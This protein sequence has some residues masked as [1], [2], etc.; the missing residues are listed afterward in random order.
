MSERYPPRLAKRM[1]ISP[2]HLHVPAVLSGYDAKLITIRKEPI[3]IATTYR[4][5]RCGRRS[6]RSDLVG[7][8]D[9]P[10]PCQAQHNEHAAACCGRRLPQPVPTKPGH[11]AGS[12]P[13]T[14]RC[15]GT[16]ARQQPG[17]LPTRADGLEPRVLRCPS[18][19]AISTCGCPRH[20]EIRQ[21]ADRRCERG[22]AR[23]LCRC[24]SPA[25]V[26]RRST[27]VAMSGLASGTLISMMGGRPPRKSSTS[28]WT[29]VSPTPSRQRRQPPERS[30]HYVAPYAWSACF[31]GSF[32]IRPRA[33][34]AR[35]QPDC[36]SR[37]PFGR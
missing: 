27:G 31:P 13:P 15:C 12:A 32:L 4:R 1:K 21:S 30:D 34:D 18:A 5:Q 8:V 36:A 3:D 2:T 37:P 24:G 11:H 14:P 35:E 19:P 26:A 16:V 29:G 10:S 22:G 17:T 7:A 28:S 25:V 9:D 6:S 33:G 23:S 20:R